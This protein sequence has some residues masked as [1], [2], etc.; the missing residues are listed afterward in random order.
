MVNIGILIGTGS[1]GED[2]LH[3][4]PWISNLDEEK[5]NVY[6]A[7]RI[8]PTIHHN[9]YISYLY[10]DE[11]FNKIRETTDKL[12]S[13]SKKYC[14]IY[15]S[16]YL[17]RK[18]SQEEIYKTQY[19]LGTSLSYISS[20][21]RRF[22]NKNKQR[23]TRDKHQ[24]NSFLVGLIKFFKNFFINNNINI[25]INTIED[26]VFSVVA[27]YV[28]KKL[29]IRTLGFMSGRFPKKAIMICE[30]FQNI[31]KWNENY[32]YVDWETIERLYD[33]STICGVD[34]YKRN[35]KRFKLSISRLLKDFRTF[36]NY[37][38]YKK[39]ITKHYFYESFI[40]IP[41]NTH[42]I[43]KHIIKYV[44]KLLIK[45]IIVE[46]KYRNELYFLFPLHYIE[47]AQI[48]F[49]EPTLNQFELIKN[50]SR[51]LPLDYKLYVKP[52][53]HYFG[54]DVS[55]KKM[56]SLS[57]LNNVRIINPNIH[58]IKLIKH[59]KGVITVNST[60]GFESLIQGIPVITF[61][62]DFYCK[63]DLCYVI[64][65]INNLA[66]TLVQCLDK[67]NPH[68]N[69]H[70][71]EDFIKKIYANTIWIEGLYHDSNIFCLSDSDGKKIA[72]ALNC[73]IKS[74]EFSQEAK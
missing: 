40:L 70:K 9:G 25:F 26:D 29:S 15:S 48:T 73:I 58:P 19:W 32:K 21:D 34:T 20:F 49:R 60:T 22:Y 33:G 35:D 10:G 64:R 6:V 59:S 16:P 31:C 2:V 3:K 68:S 74:E 72:N 12:I 56:A 44:R 43:V 41:M 24:L 52:H 18:Y 61:G 55:F 54:T 66:S 11:I 38:I 46:P 27:Y 28:A 23:D 65:D 17:K 71:T 13:K 53:P 39:N 1:A 51:A 47:D 36:I 57:K 45:S 69:Q 5:I 62:H 50:I 14:F 30:D 67:H 8:A 42:D 63:K 4:Y 7:S 37:R